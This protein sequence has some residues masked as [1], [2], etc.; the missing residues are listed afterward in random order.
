[1]KSSGCPCPL[2]Q[3]SILVFKHCPHLRSYLTAILEQVW[4]SGKIPEVL[5]KATTILIHKKESCDDPANFSKFQN[6]RVC[7]A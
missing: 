7:P 1:M 2:D 3:I 5:K 6:L 4:E